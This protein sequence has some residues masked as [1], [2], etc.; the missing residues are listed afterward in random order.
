MH[1]LPILTVTITES[2]SLS[3]HLKGKAG[4]GYDPTLYL[5]SVNSHVIA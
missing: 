4:H 2:Q 5:G 1:D 3:S